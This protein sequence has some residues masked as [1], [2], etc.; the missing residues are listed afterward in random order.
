MILFK[1]EQVAGRY[2]QPPVLLFGNGLVGRAI[3]SRLIRDA[4]YKKVYFQSGWG[5]PGNLELHRE[6]LRQAFKHCTCE[7]K[8][9]EIIWSAGSSGF[10]INVDQ[11]KKELDDFTAHLAMISDAAEQYHIPVNFR[12]MSSV[13][14][15][16]EAQRLVDIHSHPEPLRIYGTLKLNMEKSLLSCTFNFSQIIRLTSVFGYILP[17]QRRGLI[18]ALIENGLKGRVTPISGNFETLRDFIFNEDIARFISGE[19]LYPEKKG[20]EIIVLSAGKP[21]TIGEIVRMTEKIIGRR[22]FLQCSLE[23]TNLTHITCR[24]QTWLKGLHM[25]PLPV[26]ISMIYQNYRADWSG[27][28]LKSS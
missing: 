1:P 17:G 15:L 21:S 4:G 22:L 27:T 5:I 8:T 23:P 2:T 6:A 12:L 7:R 18:S 16:F 28:R 10:N 9:I 3:T 26:A 11:A 25:T 20:S 24:P 14:G 13:G 19:L